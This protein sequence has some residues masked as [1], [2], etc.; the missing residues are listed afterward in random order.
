MTD[1][2]CSIS[3]VSL[4]QSKLPYLILQWIRM[5]LTNQTSFQ[6]SS[7]LHF[8]HAQSRIAVVHNPMWAVTG[9]LFTVCG[10]G[11]HRAFYHV[12]TIA[13]INNKTIIIHSNIPSSLYHTWIFSA[14]SGYSESSVTS[15]SHFESALFFTNRHKAQTVEFIGSTHHLYSGPSTVNADLC[16]LAATLLPAAGN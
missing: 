9:V 11:G 6:Q 4:F 5:H 2:F 15:L 1:V 16:I 10:W 3:P 14:Y 12:C 7:G 13:Q 8:A